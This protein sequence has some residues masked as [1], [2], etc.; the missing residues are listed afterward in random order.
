VVAE[1]EI[2]IQA[3]APTPESLSTLVLNDRLKVDE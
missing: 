3:S 1:A 2:E